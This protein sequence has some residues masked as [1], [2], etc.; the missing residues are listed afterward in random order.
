MAAAMRTATRGDSGAN[1]GPAGGAVG[2]TKGAGGRAATHAVDGVTVGG[3]AAVASCGR[4]GSRSV[5]TVRARPSSG[6]LPDVS[7]RSREPC[8]AT[9]ALALAWSAA[10]PTPPTQPQRDVAD[11]LGRGDRGGRPSR[12]LDRG[13]AAAAADRVRG[14]APGR[15][16]RGRGAH[17]RRHRP[18]AGRRW[19]V[20]EALAARIP[21]GL[22]ARRPA[23][24]VAGRA[25][26]GRSG[27]RGRLPGHPGRSDAGR[28]PA[29]GG[30]RAPGRAPASTPARAKGDDSVEYDLR[31][32]L[33]DI[34]VDRGPAVAM[35][36]RTRFHPELGTGRPEEVVAALG[37]GPAER[38][39]CDLILPKTRCCR[40]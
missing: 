11:G 28:G 33:I 12:G 36:M 38:R 8:R 1:R 19:R 26:T 21:G 24:R 15:D 16:G 29:R 30:A 10:R 6:R 7:E 2:S 35:S 18:N 17:R 22:A 37:D 23:R 34:R 27:R 9:P 3:A 40:G 20:R 13:R 32:L 31:P 39:S 25:A 14:A 5:R 4:A